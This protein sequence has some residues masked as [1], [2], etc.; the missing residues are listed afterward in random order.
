[1]EGPKAISRHVMVDISLAQQQRLLFSS[2]LGQIKDET[3]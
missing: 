1:M 2:K 3:T